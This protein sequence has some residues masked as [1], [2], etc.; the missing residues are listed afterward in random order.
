MDG[1]TT[2]IVD[3]FLMDDIAREVRDLLST[4]EGE[5]MLSH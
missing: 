1:Q 4:L 3:S 2:H 5:F